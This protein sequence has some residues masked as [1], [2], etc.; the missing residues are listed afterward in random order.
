MSSSAPLQTARFTASRLVRATQL[1]GGAA[2]MLGN[3][4][5]V[6]NKLDEMSRVFLARRRA[7]RSS[8]PSV[9]CLRSV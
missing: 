8:S 9:R 6:L 7:E 4:L 1:W 5:F 2:L 3:L